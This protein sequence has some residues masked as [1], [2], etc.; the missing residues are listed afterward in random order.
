MRSWQA[1]PARLAAHL[2]RWERRF[3]RFIFGWIGLGN[4]RNGTAENGLTQ[5]ATAL[6]LSLY[7]MMGTADH[8]ISMDAFAS[9][10]KHGNGLLSSGN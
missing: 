1:T 5:G 6:P 9:P 4:Y 10:L 8:A 7:V 2:L 3:W